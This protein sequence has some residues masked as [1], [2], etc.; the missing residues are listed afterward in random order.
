LSSS[1]V[2][3]IVTPGAA[4]QERGLPLYARRT[5]TVVTLNRTP[6]VL[7][8]NRIGIAQDLHDSGF[9]L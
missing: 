6:R 5:G 4:L 9:V 2:S 3:F 1:S 7:K 8:S